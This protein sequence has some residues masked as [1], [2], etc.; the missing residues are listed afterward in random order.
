MRALLGALLVLTVLGLPSDTGVD[1]V[2]PESSM[3]EG[4]SC[5]N[6]STV[7]D[8]MVFKLTLSDTVLGMDNGLVRAAA[9]KVMTDMLWPEIS[10]LEGAEKYVES[11]GGSTKVMFLDTACEGGVLHK[12]GFI[13]RAREPMKT[14]SGAMLT[15]SKSSKGKVKG[16]SRKGKSRK[17]KNKGKS[18]D[19]DFTFKMRSADEESLK[20]VCLAVNPSKGLTPGWHLDGL[21]DKLKFKRQIVPEK[22]ADGTT[23][24][25]TLYAAYNSFKGGL[26]AKMF[27][28]ATTA[29]RGFFQYKDRSVDDWTDIFPIL[30]SLQVKYPSVDDWTIIKVIRTAVQQGFTLGGGV[31]V[32]GVNPAFEVIVWKTEDGRLIGGELTWGFKCKKGFDS[33]RCK[34]ATAANLKL[35][36]ALSK[37]KEFLGEG[38]K[39][40][41][42]MKLGK[43]TDLQS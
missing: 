34:A 1:Q 12:A 33:D 35:F 7:K 10:S 19:Q 29:E 30:G 21:K 41:A 24:T 22:L 43:C 8:A 23:T 3:L 13:M 11:E 5:G 25:K 16:K 14:P 42:L 17:G 38:T 27:A 36:E 26:G 9:D 4:P 40:A 37:K 2:V 39:T 31:K 20:G 32:G 6:P 28:F 18:A 15:Q